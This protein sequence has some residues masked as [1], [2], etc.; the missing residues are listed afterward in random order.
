MTC[1]DKKQKIF[2]IILA[3]L[4]LLPLTVWSEEEGSIV[5]VVP[6]KKPETHPIDEY[7]NRD[8]KNNYVWRLPQHV[9]LTAK[10]KMS[11]LRNGTIQKSPYLDYALS[12]LE[13]GNPFLS[14]YNLIT[15]SSITPIFTYG[16]PY[17]FGGRDMGNIMSKYPEY[18]L[19]RAWQNSIYYRTDVVYFLGFDCTGFV[20]EVWSKTDRESFESIE[21]LLTR[22]TSRHIYSGT[23]KEQ[24]P[25][26][27]QL[28]SNLSIG[29]VLIIKHPTTHIMMYIGT[30][31]HYG[32]TETEVPHLA[33]YLD[34]PLVIHCGVNALYADRFFSLKQSG[35][36]RYKQAT[37]P[38]GGVTVSIIG[39][40]TNAIPFHIHQQ[41]QE[42]YWFL[43]PDDA[44]LT[45]IQMDDIREWAWCR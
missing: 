45:V 30:L 38:D 34:F 29:D 13:D 33:D 42:T 19:W 41:K 22:N 14:R 35:P 1:I 12:M 28:I 31:R 8:K 44:W 10:E 23:G 39:V 11:I 15:K 5:P 17:F 24:F 43:L 9:N 27:D 7:Y 3:L 21:K 20:R 36:V 32:Y 16:V 2:C 37:V 26:Q 6:T 40:E 4:L 18:T 25:A